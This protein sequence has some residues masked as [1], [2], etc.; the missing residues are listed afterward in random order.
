MLFD[1]DRNQLSIPL[2]RP[3]NEAVY[4]S[5]ATSGVETRPASSGL[6]NGRMIQPTES[7]TSPSTP[8]VIG[9]PSRLMTQQ[10]NQSPT[11]TSQAS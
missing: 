7:V 9:R 2:V 1:D 6:A 4:K 3:E 5:L 10:T 11:P 8:S